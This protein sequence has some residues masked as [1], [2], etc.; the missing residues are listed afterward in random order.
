VSPLQIVL[1]LLAGVLSLLAYL[2]W[3]GG[4]RSRARAGLPR[5]EVVYADTGDWRQGKPLYAPRYGLSGKPDYLVRAGQEI[6]PVEVKP[7]RRA[8][9]PY[10]ADVL[11][12]AAYCLLV[13]EEFGQSPSHGLLRYRDQTFRIP[14]DR[15]LRETLLSV[16]EDMRLDL[17]ESDVPRSHDDP[18]RCRFCG[19]RAHCEQHRLVD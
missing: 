15:R 10:E 14:F 2:V 12:L 7:S 3:R 6:V 13:E 1:L 11:Q 4:T 19:H 16:M 9:E 18:T 5:G 8:S 17:E